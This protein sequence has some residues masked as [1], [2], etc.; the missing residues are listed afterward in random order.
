MKAS[1]AFA[2]Y[3]T[4]IVIILAII[5]LVIPPTRWLL[6]K[7]VLPAPGQGPTLDQRL[8]GY[9]NG[10]IIAFSKPNN[11]QSQRRIVVKISGKRDPGYGSTSRMLGE[12][13][14]CLLS[15]K[16][17]DASICG[18]LTPASAMGMALLPGLQRAGVTINVVADDVALMQD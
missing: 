16:Q 10:K 18:V 12:A 15:R 4:N 3:L 11:N 5:L 6:Q 7:F 13:A 9:W 2:A 8:N 17:A 1:S 14:L